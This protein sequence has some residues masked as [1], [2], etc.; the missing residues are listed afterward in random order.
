[1]YGSFISI[2][3][4]AETSKFTV[5]VVDVLEN[6]TNQTETLKKKAYMLA[7]LRKNQILG[8]EVLDDSIN[9]MTQDSEGTKILFQ[10]IP[11]GKTI[12][13]KIIRTLKKKMEE[14]EI[15]R[16]VVVGGAKYSYVARRTAKET[17]IELIPANF[18]SFNIFE[19]ELVPKHEIL[20][21]EEAGKLLEKFRVKSYGLPHI[22]FDDPAARSIGAKPGDIL[23]ITRKGSTA[24]EHTYYRYVV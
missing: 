8:E 18:P 17:G 14:E 4:L 2:K 7:E 10:C 12:G 15:G 24:G 23:K 19:H 11:G 9:I 16:I 13:V 22:K 6:V 1:M 3:S 21:Q 20:S 5:L